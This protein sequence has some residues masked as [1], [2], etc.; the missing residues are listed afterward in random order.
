MLMRFTERKKLR[1]YELGMDFFYRRTYVKPLGCG[2]ASYTLQIDVEGNVSPCAWY[3]KDTP[4]SL[5][6]KTTW[7]KQTIWGNLVTD[8]PMEICKVLNLSDLEKYYT[9]ENCQIL[10]K[11]VHKEN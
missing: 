10:V 11:V 8:D 2:G 1:A 4:F 5:F 9:K 6:G 7:T 3:T